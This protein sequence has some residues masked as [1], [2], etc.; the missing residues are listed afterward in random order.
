MRYRLHMESE[1][2][3]WPFEDAA[4]R[5]EELFDLAFSKGPQFFEGPEGGRYV[6]LS[7]SLYDQLVA[8][9]DATG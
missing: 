1:V 5:F 3:T 8:S 7:K 9:R 2:T 4:G 6:L